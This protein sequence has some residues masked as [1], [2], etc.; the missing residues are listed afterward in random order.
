L[1]IDRQVQ[2]ELDRLRKRFESEVQE[3]VAIEVKKYNVGA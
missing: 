3:R 2:S 1:E